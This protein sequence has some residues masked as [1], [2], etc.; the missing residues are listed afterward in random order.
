MKLSADSFLLFPVRCQPTRSICFAGFSLSVESRCFS[1]NSPNARRA[2]NCDHKLVA[3]ARHAHCPVGTH[4]HTAVHTPVHTAARSA[5]DG[6]RLPAVSGRTRSAVSSRFRNRNKSTE[7]DFKN[8]AQKAGTRRN[9]PQWPLTVART[10]VK[11][12]SSRTYAALI[13]GRNRCPFLACRLVEAGRRGVKSSA[14]GPPWLVRRVCD[15]VVGC[16]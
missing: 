16:D 14:P 8:P 11:G 10:L 9:R 3:D 4:A 2:R 12:R 6:H 7:I 1:K 15:D 13:S 5:R